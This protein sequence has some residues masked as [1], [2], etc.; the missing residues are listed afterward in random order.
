MLKKQF[1]SALSCLLALLLVLPCVPVSLAANV[2]TYAESKVTK[3]EEANGTIH[4]RNLTPW[5]GSV[6]EEAPQTTE[7]DGEIYY[8][9]EDGAD[10]A[11]FSELVNNGNSSEDST[12]R[13][14]NAVLVNDIDLGG[15]NWY[16]FR[17]GRGWNFA[18]VF[19]GQGHTIYNLYIETASVYGTGLF[20]LVGIGGKGTT[21]KNLNFVNAKS[22]TNY[23]GSYEVISKGATSIV[24]GQLTGSDSV[25]ENV[26]TSG[27]ITV[28][29][30]YAGIISAGS[31][32]GHMTRGN[33][34]NCYSD[35]YFNL[36]GAKNMVSSYETSN[37][38][39]CGVGGIIG[40]WNV[41]KTSSD[42]SDFTSTVSRCGFEGRIDAP[43]NSR[44]GGIIGNLA[45]NKY[46][47]VYQCYNKGDI[48]GYR[49]VAGVI[50][51]VYNGTAAQTG[52]QRIYNT[53]NIVAKTSQN[54]YAAGL[55]NG[56]RG[57]MLKYPAYSV[58][59]VSVR[60][61]SADSFTETCALLYTTTGSEN[62]NWGN[63]YAAYT[64]RN[65]APLSAAGVHT[66]TATNLQKLTRSQFTDGTAAEKLVYGAYTTKWFNVRGLN[67]GLPVYPWQAGKASS[68][69]NVPLTDGEEYFIEN[70]YISLELDEPGYLTV[71]LVPI[72]G[73]ATVTLG[74]ETRKISESGE[75]TFN[76]D[77]ET[78][79]FVEGKAFVKIAL[80]NQK[81]K[82]EITLLESTAIR[83][84]IP[85]ET[86]KTVFFALYDKHGAVK[87]IEYRPN[88]SVQEVNGKNCLRA[89]I[90]LTNTD[91]TDCTLKAFLWENNILDPVEHME[92]ESLGKGTVATETETEAAIKAVANG[93]FERGKAIQYDSSDMGNGI[94]RSTY[95]EKSP[96]ECTTQSVA[97]TNEADFCRDVYKEAFG[98]ELSDNFTEDESLQAGVFDPALWEEKLEIGDILSDDEGR[99]LLYTGDGKLLFAEG[100]SYDYENGRD[101]IENEGAIKE[102]SAATLSGNVKIIRPLLSYEEV[103]IN[104]KTKNRIKNLDGIVAEKI[105]SHSESIPVQIG[106]EIVFTFKVKNVGDKER[107]VT[108]K[109]MVPEN[110]QYVS[111]CDS[112]DGNALKW[113]VTVGAGETKT[114]SYKVRVPND[115]KL[116]GKYVV[117]T[118]ASVGGVSI[119]F[120]KI[121]IENLLNDTDQSRIQ[122][123]LKAMNESVCQENA[124]MA[125][126]LYTVAFSLSFALEG[127][128][129]EILDE[130]FVK[131]GGEGAGSEGVGEEAS[132]AASNLTEM[133]VPTLFGGRSLGREAESVYK[134]MRARTVSEKDLITGDILVAERDKNDTETGKMY[135]YDGESMV[136]LCSGG[137]KKESADDIIGALASYDRYVVI[138]PSVA[139]REMNHYI[140]EKD[141]NLSA[142]QEALVTTA[143]SYLLRGDRMQ[144]DDTRFN[145]DGF[146]L[147]GEF[148]W[149]KSEKH[150]EDYTMN[151][152]G[153]S[154][155][156][157]FCYDVYYHALNYDTKTYTTSLLRDESPAIRNAYVYKDD[158][159]VFTGTE[160]EKQQIINDIV[161]TIQPGDIIVIKREDG[162]GHAMFYAGNETIIHSSGSNYSYSSTPGRETYETTIR[163]KNLRD[164]FQSGD[165]CNPFERAKY[166]ALVRPLNDFNGEIPENTVNRVANMKG[167]RAEKLASQTHSVSVNPG[168]EISYTFA[169]YN[170]N[171]TA[172]TLDITDKIPENTT[173]VSGDMAV[174]GD[175]LSYKITVGADEKKTV[176]YKVKVNENTPAGTYI[177]NDAGKIGGVMVRCPDI[178]V[179]NTLTFD[180][181][182]AIKAAIEE[183]GDSSLTGVQ[184]ANE[185]YKKAFGTE[186]ILPETDF[187]GMEADI[188]SPSDVKT[189]YHKLNTDGGTCSKMVVD[190]LYGGRYFYTPLWDHKRI[191]L[192]RPNNLVVGD[193]IFIRTASSTYLMIYDGEDFVKLDGSAA[194]ENAAKVLEK[195]LAYQNYFVVLRPSYVME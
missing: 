143:Y 110:T 77:A 109:D 55:V 106:E 176:S 154:N 29:S 76:S 91:V 189:G 79:L 168:D 83:A 50:G 27:T 40:F 119:A 155:C 120:P 37:S 149:Q 90:D 66:S 10:L 59:D 129:S 104:D 193:L 166:F 87:K 16:D 163:F 173:H 126:M 18:G 133:T 89:K 61:S 177:K 123:A 157:A 38:K 135:M 41:S 49:Q 82:G 36:S 65:K 32:V 102:T 1:T 169:V 52:P 147:N 107:S 94:P 21:I 97:Y 58:G 71:E 159:G 75:Y 39:P 140:E 137:M 33:V 63:V 108:I 80:L 182:S 125:K 183:T 54:T 181:Q 26:S 111:G 160:K 8:M 15:V 35:V 67:D 132:V 170:S 128:P 116:Y 146:S 118:D 14:S 167:I 124:S 9:I 42:P 98:I 134:T 70:S 148:R 161:N 68:G 175:T 185:I 178:C 20:Y 84:V 127:T 86:S 5:D 92:I 131:G 191:R 11:W 95:G 78:T 150:P 187:A 103:F 112:R 57:A 30:S 74:D 24:C 141:L 162:S 62:V 28:G 192:G 60:E 115:K 186:T 165:K 81:E 45:A 85:S 130:I 172:V 48:T 64:D 174:N 47:T 43:Q 51:W 171:D 3:I 179:K 122:T 25:I 17:I 142:K 156:A 101:Y 151:Q 96:E 145:A 153:Y 7:I 4:S 46:Y 164:L 13:E 100:K 88:L 136:E 180:E 73:D 114:V 2:F 121:L 93:Y 19:D 44:V 158:D 105:S 34:L 53:G 56:L 138:R 184:L 194:K 69:S 188:F 72:D 12:N 195:A 23:T 117:S 31:I 113:L 6:A 144:Y 22:V 190:S 152:W 99:L 139:L